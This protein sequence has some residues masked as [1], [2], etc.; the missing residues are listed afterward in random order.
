MLGKKVVCIWVV[1]IGYEKICLKVLF[2]CYGY[3]YFVYGL[4][5]IYLVNV[6]ELL[7]FFNRML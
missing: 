2:V 1:E 6:I 4:I 3:L 5:S 7:N